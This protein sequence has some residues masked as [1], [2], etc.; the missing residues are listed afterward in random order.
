[1]VLSSLRSCDRD[2]CWSDFLVGPRDVEP[3]FALLSVLSCDRDRCCLDVVVAP[4]RLG[5]FSATDEAL[6]LVA[7]LLGLLPD[8][9]DSELRLVR[10][11]GGNCFLLR[12][13]DELLLLPDSPPLRSRVFVACMCR[14]K[15]PRKV[16]CTGEGSLESLLRSRIVFLLISGDIGVD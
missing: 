2:L 9:A 8:G 16:C 14:S 6:L 7:V 4:R 11:D 10:P 3:F 1:M 5:F 13:S 15:A 12:L